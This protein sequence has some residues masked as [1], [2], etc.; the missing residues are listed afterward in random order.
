MA[1]ALLA[2]RYPAAQV[3]SA[4][5]MPEDSVNAF[6]VGAMLEDGLD[7]SNHTPAPVSPE[8]ISPETLVITLTRGAFDNARQWRQTTGFELE[9][10]D[11]PDVPEPEGPREMIFDGFR[12]IREAL[13]AHIRNRF[14][15]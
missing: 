12:A 8:S 2:A 15:S 5:M 4:G 3:A 14:G 11:M 1:A 7:I 6:A 10:W 9:F 13:K